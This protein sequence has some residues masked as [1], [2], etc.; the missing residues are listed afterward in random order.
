MEILSFFLTKFVHEL[1]VHEFS[2]K[3]FL[4]FFFAEGRQSVH[5]DQDH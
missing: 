1:S 3:S 4:L 2:A 5:S